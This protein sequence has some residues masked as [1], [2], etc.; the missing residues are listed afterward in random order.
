[1]NGYHGRTLS[2]STKRAEVSTN[3]NYDFVVAS[4]NDIAD[5][6]AIVSK[7]RPGSLAAIL[8]EPMRG[9]GGCVP[10]TSTF[11]D[12]LRSLATSH[13]AVLIFDEVMTS[14]LNYGGLQAA[15]GIKPDI[16][17]VGKYLGGG[18]S[19][20]AFGGRREILEMFDPRTGK[21]THAGTFNNNIFTM[22]AGVAG[23]AILNREIL[24][25]LNSLGDN[26]RE[27]IAL[28]IET[29][30]PRQEGVEPK[31]FVQGVGSIL[32][33]HFGGRHYE[34]LKALFYHHMLD[35][36]IFIAARGFIALSIETK[37]HHV[38]LFLRALA[39]YVD[40]CQISWC[41]TREWIIFRRR[42]CSFGSYQCF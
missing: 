21:A 38:E 5:T 26:L 17:T 23:A 40:N 32:A 42:Q 11:L 39:E 14:R 9:A 30:I 35:R 25:Q 27:K 24:D 18:M 10:G 31:M 20:G 29:C 36:G 33:V 3:S 19:F 37:A 15:F 2:S 16:T 6:D 7:V 41:K 8:V 28:A 13:G 1:M 22:A 12:H 4:Y 34:I